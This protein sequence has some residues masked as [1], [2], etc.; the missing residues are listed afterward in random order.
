MRHPRPV[1]PLRRLP[2][3][4]LADLLEGEGVH[5]RVAAGGDER[6]HSAHRVRATAVAGLDEQLAVGAHERDGHGHGRAVGE[7]ELGAVAE[8][9]DDAEDVVPAPRVEAGRVVTQLVEDLVH[10]E[11]CED[12]LDQDGGLDRPPWYAEPVLRPAEDVVPQPRLEMRLELREV[13][14]APVA[15]VVA[16]EVEAEVEQRARHRGAVDLE[17]ALVEMPAAR[18]DEQHRDLLVQRVALLARVELDRPVER[19]REVALP[20][21]AVLPGRR[22]RV[23]EVGHEDLRPRV[24]GVDHHLAVDGAR[25]LDAPVGDL[26]RERRDAPVSVTDGGSVGQEVGQLAAR[27]SVEPLGPSRE[28]LAPALPELPLEIGEERDRVRGQDVVDLH[29][30]IL[31]LRDAITEARCAPARTA[32]SGIVGLVPETPEELHARAAGALRM[33]PVEEWDTFPF[34]GDLRPRALLPPAE[35]RAGEAR[36]GR[37]R[38]PP[39]QPRRR[40]VPLDD[41]ALAALDVRP[42]DRPA[43]RRVARAPGALRRA[44][45]PS[46]GARRRARRADR[47]NR[48]R[49]TG[50]RGDRA[51]ARLSLG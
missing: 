18:P 2:V 27:Q 48:A 42:S 28:E 36:R 22:V 5:L 20:L 23:L 30:P 38:L 31:S 47:A 1:E 24:E 19:V 4:V 46:R 8:L 43:A 3:L 12:R 40:R 14:V 17:V 32:A 51:R 13:E 21:D 35:A 37:R 15:T 29:R 33:P 34:A 26:L 50:D 49:G 45:R 16:Q 11:G 7:H 39:L 44:R 9:L 10:L 41:G 25:D 6:G